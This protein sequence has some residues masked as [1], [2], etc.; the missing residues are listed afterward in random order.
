MNQPGKIQGLDGV[1]ALACLWVVAHHVLCFAPPE[2]RTGDLLGWMLFRGDRGVP[3]FFVLSGFLLSMPLLKGY[4]DGRAPRWD[5]YLV[6]RMTRIIPGYYACLIACALVQAR[7][8]NPPDWSSVALALGFVNSFFPRSYY[9]LASNTPLWSIGA[10]VVFYALLP[11][12]MML[13]A[14]CRTPLRVRAAWLAVT[15]GLLAGNYFFVERVAEWRGAS[16]AGGGPAGAWEAVVNN[17]IAL[18]A[19][20]LVGVLSAEV[21]LSARRAGWGDPAPGASASRPNNLMRLRCCA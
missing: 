2:V 11:P 18:F 6:R 14:R 8:R 4:R 19:H 12:F 17:P 1:R 10:E 3:I 13:V 21:L 5:V 20:F 9:P 15:L 7:T 16:P